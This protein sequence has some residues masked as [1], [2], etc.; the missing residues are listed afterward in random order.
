MACLNF[1][2]GG[3]IYYSLR[4]IDY[5]LSYQSLGLC[6]L[7]FRIEIDREKCIA[8]GT[9]FIVDPTHFELD[10]NR[11][12]KVVGGKTNG[13]S[14]GTFNDEEVEAAQEAEDSCP[15]SV[16]KVTTQI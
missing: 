13:K 10:E 12:S 6:Y 7:K 1:Y 5:L 14:E 16:I 4:V 3:N 2:N 11:K 8:C 15:V 9:C